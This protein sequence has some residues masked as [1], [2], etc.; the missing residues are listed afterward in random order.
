MGL[1][2]KILG[3]IMVSIVAVFIIGGMVISFG[4]AETV[5]ILLISGTLTVLVVVGLF[6]VMN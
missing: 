1:L 5:S 4:I 2:K 3:W 6:L